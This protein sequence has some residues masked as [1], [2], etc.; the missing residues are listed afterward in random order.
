MV[1]KDFW[2]FILAEQ[3]RG[4]ENMPESYKWHLLEVM[5]ILALISFLCIFGTV[6][7]HHLVLTFL[8]I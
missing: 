5:R 1:N 3:S 8:D 2:K 6:L 4:M 7:V